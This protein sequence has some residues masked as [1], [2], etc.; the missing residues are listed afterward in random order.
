M[1]GFV[2]P[3]EFRVEK[4]L[5]SA[6][7]DEIIGITFSETDIDRMLTRV[8][9]RMV[10]AGRISRTS[11]AKVGG[12]P[13]DSLT[14]S[15]LAQAMQNSPATVGFSGAAGVEAL[16]GW[17][18]SSVVVVKSQGKS[19]MGEGI[20]YLAPITAAAYRTGFP[21]NA[22]R[23]RR[24]DKIIYDLMVMFLKALD[25]EGP[26]QILKRYC[27]ETIG[28]GVDFGAL[29]HNEPNYDG[30]SS[31]DVSQLLA[32]RFV[33]LFDTEGLDNKT[34]TE[35]FCGVVVPGALVPLGRDLVSLFQV[36]AG[37]VG[38]GAT[39]DVA[40]SF[41]ALRSV[42]AIRL[43]QIPLRTSRALRSAFS[44]TPHSDLWQSSIDQESDEILRAEWKNPLEIY[45]DFTD[46]ANSP[47]EQLAK[48]CVSRDLDALRLFFRDRMLYRATIQAGSQTQSRHIFSGDSKNSKSRRAIFQ[49]V[50][51]A[52][53]DTDYHNAA[54]WYL[55][56]LE[57][58]LKDE[59]GEATDPQ[60]LRTLH[61]AREIYDNPLHAFAAVIAAS[62]ELEGVEGLIKWLKAT[63]GLQSAGLPKGYGVFRG[64]E[65]QRSTWKYRPNEELILNLVD[66]CFIDSPNSPTKTGATV[67]RKL[68]LGTLL[69]R[70]RDRYGILV[71]T[72]PAEFDNPGTRQAASE[73]L[74]AFTGFLRDIG[75]F[76]TLSDDF[77]GN[78]VL[79][80]RRIR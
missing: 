43:F 46:V 35:E 18:R 59:H 17:L 65:G 1:T 39:W 48:Q 27:A 20:D 22:Q 73:N 14:V 45:C 21:K 3:D 74:R 66:L 80:P 32:L 78:E 7:V 5:N 38:K 23:H 58:Q 4:N 69:A 71:D 16:E 36:M 34:D 2:F 70:L 57:V 60:S 33:E 76:E 42:V 77:E 13:A 72:P 62:R 68:S 8:A 10:K 79:R 67:R 28:Q 51:R 19:R 40:D 56:N 31:L 25:I 49:E 44:D 53:D 29:P 55:N 50:L 47:S 9:E 26:H 30:K 6:N 61:E 41:S 11:K 52:Q 12:K 54:N 24:A 63:G 75:C 64:R 37:H 15:E